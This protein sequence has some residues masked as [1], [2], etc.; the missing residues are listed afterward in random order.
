MASCGHGRVLPVVAQQAAQP[1]EGLAEVAAHHRRQPEVVEDDPRV[2]LVAPLLGRLQ[3]EPE[4][5]L[6]LDP[7]PSATR[8][9][10]RVLPHLAATAESSPASS[11]ARSR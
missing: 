6:R 5:L 8:Q 7:A 3:R 2:E 4:D 11:T 1:A 9:S 10:P